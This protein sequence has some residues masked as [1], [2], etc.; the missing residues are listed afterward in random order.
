ME[1]LYDY[2]VKLNTDNFFL[3]FNAWINFLN[4]VEEL[5]LQQQS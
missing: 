1:W 3:K 5:K 2:L 4:K